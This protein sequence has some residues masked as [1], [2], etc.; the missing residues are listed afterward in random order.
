MN[1]KKEFKKKGLGSYD[2]K[3]IMFYHSERDP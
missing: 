3:Q 2:S 1:K